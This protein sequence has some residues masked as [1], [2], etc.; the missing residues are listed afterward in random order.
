MALLPGLLVSS[1]S[2]LSDLSRVGSAAE[3]ATA[4][5]FP[6]M[7]GAFVLAPFVTAVPHRWLRIAALLGLPVVMVVPV[8]VAYA[9]AENAN[10]VWTSALAILVYTYSLILF[11]VLLAPRSRE[12]RFIPLVAAYGVV[13]VLSVGTAAFGFDACFFS[14]CSAIDKALMYVGLVAILFLLPPAFVVTIWY[15][16]E[17]NCGSCERRVPR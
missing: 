15:G 7:L 3:V 16:S 12:P 5:S 9:L 2:W 11:T 8:S 17:P 14:S 10:V 1:L 13:C 6:L 4:W